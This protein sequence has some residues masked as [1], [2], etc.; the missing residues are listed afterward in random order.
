MRVGGHLDR[1][2]QKLSAWLHSANSG[3]TPFL[4][5]RWWVSCWDWWALDVTQAEQLQRIENG[6]TF[7]REPGLA[8]LYRPKLRFEEWQDA[9][10]TIHE[11]WI[12]FSATGEARA[13]LESITSPGGYCHIEDADALIADGLRGISETL[14]H[15]KV[16]FQW[17]AQARFLGLLASVIASQPLAPARRIVQSN[18]SGVQ[19]PSLIEEVEAFIR[20]RIDQPLSVEDLARHAG[21]SLSSF[22]HRYRELA[23]E[24]PYRTIVRLKMEAAK[25]LL[26]QENKSVKETADRLGFSS[27]FH[28]S[29]CF[30][31]MEGL[32]PSA[33]VKAMT[34]K[35]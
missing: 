14:F 10:R 4:Q 16:G 32:S 1:S 35:Q 11:S 28:F 15:R 20:S 8:A 6:G 24:S 30:K 22:A 19:R 34:I 27:E 29:R 7:V 13:A 18:P 9:G 2:D 25:H 21:Q 33:H 23:G 17:Q 31:R 3:P 26:V 12:L 5:T